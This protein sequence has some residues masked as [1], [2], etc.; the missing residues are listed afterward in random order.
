MQTDVQAVPQGDGAMTS[1]GEASALGEHGESASTGGTVRADRA[2]ESVG[3][4]LS[5]AL[6][7]LNCTPVVS[8]SDLVFRACDIA[9]LRRLLAAAKEQAEREAGELKTAR[10]NVDLARAETRRVLISKA[11][12]TRGDAFHPPLER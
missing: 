12:R 3:V 10:R 2:P 11:D 8:G 4:K 1:F 5:N 9:E 6:V 7:V